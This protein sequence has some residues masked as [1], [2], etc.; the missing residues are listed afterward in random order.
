MSAMPH[1]PIGVAGLDFDRDYDDEDRP[2][3]WRTG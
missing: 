2:Q 3:D 1:Q